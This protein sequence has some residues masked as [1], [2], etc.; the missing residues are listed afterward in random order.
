MRQLSTQYQLT[1]DDYPVIETSSI[2]RCKSQQFCFNWIVRRVKDQFQRS[3]LIQTIIKELDNN[4]IRK[5]FFL[6]EFLSCLYFAIPSFRASFIDA[7]HLIFLDQVELCA[8]S[9]KQCNLGELSQFII[10]TR[11]TQGQDSPWSDE[12][13]PVLGPDQ[14][15]FC[16]HKRLEFLLHFC[17]RCFIRPFP[18][19]LLKAILSFFRTS[20]IL[21]LSFPFPDV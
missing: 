15:G 19:P 9:E 18:V 4:D 5:E 12:N 7:F 1:M 8:M 6:T 21:V 14:I 2:I 13:C 17:S 16:S 10:N 3:L 20:I 11:N